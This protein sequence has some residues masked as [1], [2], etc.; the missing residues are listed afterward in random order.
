[1]PKFSTKAEQFQ[2][3]VEM[4]VRLVVKLVEKLINS[5]RVIQQSR[6]CVRIQICSPRTANS[7]FHP[8]CS[9]SAEV[10]IQ[11]TAFCPIGTWSLVWHRRNTS[12]QNLHRLS[13][14]G[15]RI[16]K[17]SERAAQIRS[18]ALD[19][20]GPTKREL[21]CQ[22]LTNKSRRRFNKSA[23]SISFQEID[24]QILPKSRLM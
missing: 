5:G 11:P 10:Q 4:L 15:W 9:E 1:M 21:S 7:S 22:A 18:S 12:S 17:D 19:N 8:A 14:D 6:R 16:G 13:N 23:M 2:P 24:D 20:T 3:N